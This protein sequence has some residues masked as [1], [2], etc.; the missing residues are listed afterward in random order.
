M[1]D[2]ADLQL[3][4]DQAKQ[5]LREI[6]EQR[7]KYSDDVIGL[8]D[9]VEGGMRAKQAELAH[10]RA[11]Y[12]RLLAEQEELKTMLA[13]LLASV[14]GSVPDAGHDVLRR[15]ASLGNGAMDSASELNDTMEL[16]PGE[17]RLGMQRLLRSG[18]ARTRSN[19]GAERQEPTS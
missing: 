12:Q 16:P 6:E 19:G 7:T 13:S 5:S 11:E 1:K 8:I 15:I 10:N 3:R 9:E 2:L 18:R 14:D 17:I 4:L